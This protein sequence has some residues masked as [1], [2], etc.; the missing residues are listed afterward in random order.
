MALTADAAPLGLTEAE[1]QQRRRDGRGNDAEDRSSR[2]YTR[3]L[4]TNVFTFFNDIL[5]VIGVALLALGRTNDAVVSVGLG[6]LNAVISAGQEIRAKRTL[7]RLKLL[8]RAPSRVVRDGQDRDV[9]AEDVVQGDLVRLR[10]GDQIVVDGAVV[11]PGR[12]EVDESLLTGES[13]PVVKSAG[14]PLLSGTY[15]LTG[16]ALQQAEAVG[17]ASYASSL[18]AAARVWTTDRTPLQARIDLVVRIAMLLVALM[19]AAILL[20]AA[21]EGL[22]L[23]RVAQTSA[24]L[25][26]LVPYGLFFLV[27]ASYA[28]GAAALTRHGALVQQLNAVESLSN[29]DVICTDKTGTLTTGLLHLLEVL[30]VGGQ[31]DVRALLGRVAHSTTAPNATTR[32]LVSG[33]P[34][35]PEPVLEEVPFSSARRWSA[36]ALGGTHPGVFVLGAVDTLLPSLREQDGRDLGPLV[37]ERTGQGSRVLLLAQA[38]AAAGLYVA[39]DSEPRLARLTPLALVVLGDEL[40]PGV[41]QAVAGLQRR[42]VALK[43]VSGDD[44]RTV[45]ALVAR[46]GLHDEAPTTGAQLAALSSADFDTAVAERT[47]FGRIAPEQKEQ[48]VDALRRRGHYVAMIGDGVNDTRCLKR[49]NVGIAMQSGSSVTR[50]V[51]DVVLLDDSFAALEPAQSAGQ[52]I[53]AGIS[54]ALHLFLARA[55][56]AMLVIV[57]VSILGIGFPYEPAQVGLTLFT[58]GLPALLLTAWARPAPPDPQLLARVARFVLPASVVTAMFAVT[59]YAAFYTLIRVGLT[60]GLIP[61]EGVRDFEA[62][63]GLTG[64]DTS[65][66]T[67]AATGV[68]QTVLSMFTAVTAFLLILF[69]APPSKL[70]TGWTGVD[71][72]KRPAMLA[73]G[74]LVAFLVVLLTPVTADYFS[75]LRPGGPEIPAVAVTTVVWFF[76]L[77]ACWRYQVADRLLGL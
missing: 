62:F 1:A 56:T 15:C 76:V 75:L 30:P 55:L 71:P 22:T 45:A 25:S 21:L 48:I 9:A 5:F 61:E 6:L 41:E 43:V 58:V 77:R 70:F 54:V 57:G 3:I 67:L 39:G 40:R 34:G 74:L 38:E 46:L 44:P 59:L 8:N 37:E 24:V 49:A 72:D 18:T 47:V 29:V 20:Q 14:D 10:P 50:D 17:P 28:V 12:L 52:R 31:P 35:S 7:D 32:A 69:L 68:A 23:L 16:T 51:A 36:V 42:G 27:S 73:V 53:I 26:G 11:G 19:S 4:R 33:L 60:G 13:E 66:V 2:S 64:G 63:T 65:F